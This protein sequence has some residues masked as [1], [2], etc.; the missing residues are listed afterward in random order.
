M[1]TL[2]KSE[3]KWDATLT[4]NSNSTDMV[5]YSEEKKDMGELAPNK[6][7]NSINQG[8]NLIVG[9]YEG[10]QSAC[11]ATGVH[12]SEMLNEISIFDNK[13]GKAKRIAKN[14]DF[15]N[16]MNSNEISTSNSTRV[17]SVINFS[18]LL[19]SPSGITSK[20]SSINDLSYLYSQLGIGGGFESS[21][22]LQSLSNDP[23]IQLPHMD[24]PNLSAHTK[25]YAFRSHICLS[26]LCSQNIDKI[27][28]TNLV[29]GDF[30]LKGPGFKVENVY[31]PIR[32]EKQNIEIKLTTFTNLGK[33]VDLG[34]DIPISAIHKSDEN[35]TFWLSLTSDKDQ[36]CQKYN[37]ILPE[38]VFRLKL[39]NENYKA[40]VIH[41]RILVNVKRVMTGI[42]EDLQI[43]SLK[44]FDH[45]ILPSSGYYSSNNNQKSS[46]TL[47]YVGLYNDSLDMEISQI[48]NSNP[49]LLSN[50]I[51]ERI[52]SAGHYKIN[53]IDVLISYGSGKYSHTLFVQDETSRQPLIDYLNNTNENIE[54]LTSEPSNA[55]EMVPPGVLPD[56]SGTPAPW[57][58]E[59]DRRKAME[60]ACH[61][62]ALRE[63]IAIQYLIDTGCTNLPNPKFSQWLNPPYFRI[64]PQFEPVPMSYNW[65]PNY[66]NIQLIPLEQPKKIN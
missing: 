61:R 37:D 45:N 31:I 50:Y 40:G 2:T 49:S 60:L 11:M 27:I 39:D 13:L 26:I 10:I 57:E 52:N 9:L 30:K 42:I 65:G 21:G 23:T 20:T 63:H 55:T 28:E 64:G 22:L 15:G 66:T 3:Q 8:V 54:W 48:L 59:T 56:F 16:R 36:S 32:N 24:V 29:S 53:D 6:F 33:R 38:A 44:V 41:P 47:I 58:V 46:S 25:M 7:W 5:I 18:D 19:T 12:E 14:T 35:F 4:M 17:S 43:S 51:I 34:V 1:K 62:V